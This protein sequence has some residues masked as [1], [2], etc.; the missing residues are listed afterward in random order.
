MVRLLPFLVVFP[1]A[2][3]AEEPVP[4]PVPEDVLQRAADWAERTDFEKALAAVTIHT[5]AEELD[6]DGKVAHTNDVEQRVSDQDGKPHTEVIRAT[7]DGKDTK[8][9][10]QQ[11][12]DDKK[13]PK[14]TPSYSAALPFAREQ[15]GSSLHR[16]HV[17]HALGREME[18]RTRLCGRGR[19]RRRCRGGYRRLRSFGR[20]GAHQHEESNAMVSHRYRQRMIR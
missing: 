1:F 8:E 13:K 10:M 6:G 17:T 2:A 14:D 19:H 16:H 7:R 9:E 5:I 4:S 12:R 3:F 20:A 15:H 18:E 11:K